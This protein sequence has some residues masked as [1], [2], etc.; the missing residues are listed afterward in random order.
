M[1]ASL[2][3]LYLSGNREI[4][5]MMSGRRKQQT[6]LKATLTTSRKIATELSLTDVVS[7]CYHHSRTNDK[8]RPQT[9]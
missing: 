4:N 9:S 1:V 5:V 2:M 7:T 8:A 3:G 6:I